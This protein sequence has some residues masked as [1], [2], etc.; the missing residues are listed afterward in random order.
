VL[1]LAHPGIVMPAKRFYWVEA[2]T[3]QAAFQAS[4][5]GNVITVNAARARKLTFHLSDRLLKLDKPVVIRVNG[6]TVHE[7]KIERSLRVT[8][9]DAAFVK[10]SERFATARVTADVPDLPVGEKW[11]ATMEPKTKPGL[12]AYWEDFAVMTWKEERPGLPAEVEQVNEGLK[13]PSGY[14][15]LHVKS[16]PG[17][18]PFRPAAL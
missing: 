11:L 5:E 12:L 2:D 4:V 15:V 8:V 1:R 18:S 9:E 16:V 6:K 10:D 13:V 17:N 7:K 3:H 14:A